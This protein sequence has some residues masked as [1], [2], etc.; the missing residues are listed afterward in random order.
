[1]RLRRALAGLLLLLAAPVL[2]H[3]A[4]AR[5][6]WA[7]D[8]EEPQALVDRATLSVQEIMTEGDPPA[9][10]DARRLLRQARAVVVCPQVFRAGFI[11]GGQSGG[12]VMLARDAA[13]SW[14]APAFYGLASASLG[15]QIGAQDM[16]ILMLVMNDAALGALMDSQFKFG[17]DASVSVATIGAGIAGATT[18]AAGADVVAVARARGLF[19]GVALEGSLLTAR[20]GWNRAYYGQEFGP[21]Q[22]VVA[23]QA[24][25]PGADPLRGVLMRFGGEQAPPVLPQASGQS[26]A[27]PPVARPR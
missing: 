20:S 12:C 25:N 23:M 11:L 27:L 21:R 7:Q 26:T 22:I 6:A 9:L 8:R 24:N 16:Q 15:L 18:S 14:S 17:G 5:A 10:E 19:A 3:A 13:G 1:M 2:G 4:W